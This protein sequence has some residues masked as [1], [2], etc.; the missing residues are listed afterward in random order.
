[1]RRPAPLNGTGIRSLKCGGRV[2]LLPDFHLAIEVRPGAAYNDRFHLNVSSLAVLSANS[3]ES[4][5]LAALIVQSVS[6]IFAF[7]ARSVILHYFSSMVTG[8]VLGYDSRLL[9]P[10]TRY[11]RSNKIV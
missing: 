6:L 8:S 5:A 7:I 3:E 10:A 2:F 9:I 1:M 11:A 4:P